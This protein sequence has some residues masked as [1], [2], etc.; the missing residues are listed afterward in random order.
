MGILS[1]YALAQPWQAL[2]DEELATVRSN[3]IEF[4]GFVEGE[5]GKLKAPSLDAA[6]LAQHPA[7]LA[8]AAAFD[9]SEKAGY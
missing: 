6:A 1:S 7:V 8:G 4:L 2:A 5:G 9:G 3:L